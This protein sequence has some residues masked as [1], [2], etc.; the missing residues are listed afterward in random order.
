MDIK[1]IVEIGENAHKRSNKD[2]TEAA[3]VL[4]KEFEDTKNLLIQLSYHLDSVEKC[5]YQISEE[6]KSRKTL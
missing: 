4:K 6:I 1:E 5:Y 3:S 2:L